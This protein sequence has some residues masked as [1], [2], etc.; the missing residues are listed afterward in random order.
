L[1]I[2]CP[3][4]QT[5]YR[6]DAKALTTPA[7]R[8][9]RCAACGHSW[10]YPPAALGTGPREPAK[11]EPPPLEP[12]LAAPIFPEPPTPAAPPSVEPTVAVPAH[13][14]PAPT[15][16]TAGPA[17]DRPWASLLAAA[18]ETGGDGPPATHPVDP[19]PRRRRW[20]TVGL[21]MLVVLIVVLAALYLARP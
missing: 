4:C 17:G 14:E 12:M 7:G 2:T 15:P 18:E 5:R 21:P 8:M 13:P 9:V 3:R 10:H 20:L 16:A 11:A 1:I 19:L 6:V